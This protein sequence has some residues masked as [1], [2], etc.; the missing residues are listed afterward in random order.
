MAPH[1]RAEFVLDALNMALWVKN[2]A[3]NGTF[4][5]MTVVTLKHP[6][7]RPSRWIGLPSSI[8]GLSGDEEEFYR[9]CS[10]RTPKELR[11]L[12]RWW[13]YEY[14]HRCP[15]LALKGKTPAE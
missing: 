1:L 3:E 7:G 6:E 15:H 4:R 5:G 9:G 10:F 8:G 13:E 14:N 2:L 12:L 11:Q